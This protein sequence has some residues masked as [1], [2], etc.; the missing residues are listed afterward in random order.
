[1]Q[2][3][4]DHEHRKLSSRQL[5][6]WSCRRR[7]I[8]SYTG[9]SPDGQTLTY[10]FF[11]SENWF[12][13][14]PQDSLGAFHYAKDSGNY[15]R[16]SNG[17][18]RFGLFGIISGGGPL[19]SVGIFWP[20]F[21]VPFLTNWFFPLIRE[22]RKGKKVARAIPIGWPKKMQNVVPFSSGISTDLWPL[23]LA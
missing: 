7:T 10:M 17:K 22:F 19:I 15:S 9:I 13:I 3:P 18:V 21:A 5:S 1:M 4:S 12:M 8:I 2:C 14:T 6:G 23:G 11:F 16:N 20:K